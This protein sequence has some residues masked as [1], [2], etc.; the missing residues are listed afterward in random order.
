MCNWDS[1]RVLLAAPLLLR[2]AAQTAAP[3]AAGGGGGSDCD[4]NC[5]VV[6]VVVFVVVVIVLIVVTA[7]LLMRRRPPDNTP[8]HPPSHLSS[9]GRQPSAARDER[10]FAELPVQPQPAEHRTENNAAALGSGVQ[11]GW[12][13]WSEGHP[14]PKV[15]FY[16]PDEARPPSPIVLNPIETSLPPAGVYARSTEEPVFVRQ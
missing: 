16:A 9:P 2:A 12:G 1:R 14:P 4:E 6:I 15:T 7:V 13:T 10:E 8:K 11:P 3:T 5:V